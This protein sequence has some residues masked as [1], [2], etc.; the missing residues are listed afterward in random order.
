MLENDRPA[1]ADVV[2]HIDRCLSCL[3]VH[4]DVPVGRAL[5][6][7]DRPRAR[8]RRAARFGGR[9]RERWLRAALAAVLPYPRRVRAALALAALARPFARLLPAPLRAMLALA[10]RAPRERA[11]ARANAG[12]RR[13]SPRARASASRSSR[14]ACRPCIAPE[15][16][17]AT[18]RLLERCG[19]EVVTVGGC[20]GALVHH[21][22]KERARTRS[23]RRSSSGCT[24]SS[25]ARGLDAIVA[26]A[27]GCGTHV[28]DYGYV[29][30]DDAR[31]RG[32]RRG[33][34][35]AKARDVTE[36][37]AEL[38][39]PPRRADAPSAGR[40]LSLRVLD[41]ARPE[42][43]AAAARAARARGLRGQ[44]DC[45]RAPLLRL[46]RHLQC[47]AARARDAVARPQARAHRAHGRRR[48]RDRQ[49][50][51]HHAARGRRRRRPSCTRWSCSIGRRAGRGRPRSR[52]SACRS[53]SNAAGSNGGQ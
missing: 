18:I 46:R 20:C 41:A 44:G 9:W 6:A 22:G 51:L 36:V 45:R 25:T 52:T 49:H 35:S 16:N 48:R 3:V 14:A 5:P 21:S 2:Q 26:N 23:R 43:R 37:L 19:A 15:I 38:G 30:R 47:S 42:G 24:P 40:G 1:T 8:A 13:R 4:D 28:K 39:L 10:P 34:V 11:A 27:S 17:A 12:A 29:F 53:A 50:R 33:R 32:A 7:P 31:A